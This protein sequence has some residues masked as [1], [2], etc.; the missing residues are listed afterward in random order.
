MLLVLHFPPFTTMTQ[1]FALQIPADEKP[2]HCCGSFD[3]SVTSSTVSSPVDG[4]H[5]KPPSYT[6]HTSLQPERDELP[7][8]EFLDTIDSTIDSLSTELRR[9]SLDIHGTW[10]VYEV[11]HCASDSFS[12]AFSA[13]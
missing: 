1:R 3:C 5:T 6:S 11:S 13:M 4:L 9:L 12:F 2:H 7:N 10:R 8:T